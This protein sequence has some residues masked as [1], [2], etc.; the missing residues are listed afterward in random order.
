MKLIGRQ[1]FLGGNPQKER[2]S[3]LAR[4]RIYGVFTNAF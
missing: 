1:G 4:N 3:C 2:R